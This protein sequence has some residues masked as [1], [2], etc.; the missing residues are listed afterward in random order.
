MRGE[1]VGNLYVGIMP[2]GTS[3]TFVSEEAYEQ[4]YEEAYLDD[5]DRQH[6]LSW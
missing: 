6:D 4:A 3:V 5:T 1:K 2:D